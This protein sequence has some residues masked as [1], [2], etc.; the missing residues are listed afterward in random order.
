MSKVSSQMAPRGSGEVEAKT[1]SL[2]ERLGLIALIDERM[3]LGSPEL[4]IVPDLFNNLW[5]LVNATASGSRIDRFRPEEARNGFGT[6]EINGE[7]GENLGRLNMVYLKKPIPCYYLVYV[8]VG[9]PFRRKGLGKRILEYFKD[10]LIE[11]SAIGIL[12]NIIPEEDPSYN[13]YSRQ[14]WEPV[15]AFIGDGLGDRENNFM[16]YVPSRWQGKHLKEPILKILHHL[17]RKRAAIDMRDNEVMVQRTISEFKDL[18]VA[19]LTYFKGEIQTGRSTPLAQ[20]MFTRFATKLISFRRRIGTLL[21]YTG[22]ES[23]EQIVLDP[24]V[25]ALPVR[26]YPPSELGGRSPSVLG[27]KELWSRLPA[28]LKKHPARFIESLPNYNR[29]S[30]ASWLKERGMFFTDK[31][32][33][34][35]LMSLGFDPT[36]LKELVIENEKFIFERMQARQLAELEKKEELLRRVQLE[37]SHARPSNAQL[38][39]NPPLLKILSRGNVYVLRRKVG[40]IHWEEAIEELQSGSHLKNMNQTMKIDRVILRTVRNANRM[41]SEKLGLREE[42]VADSLACFVPWSLEDNQP[43]LVIDFTNAYLETVWM[44]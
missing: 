29:P 44:A 18:Y 33:V 36:R 28:M 35:D 42:A 37:M 25:A 39:V 23:I 21:G 7:G 14:G 3:R 17:K 27:D 9:G 16:I 4:P 26:T 20:F 1:I 8:E 12:D 13:I 24:S 5:D 31:L 41:I 34:G 15:E 19:L 2:N 32:T 11:K 38:R 22:G 30:L 10:F 43:R 40:G 6:F